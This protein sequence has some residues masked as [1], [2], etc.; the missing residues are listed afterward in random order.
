MSKDEKP[1]TE[2]L[3]DAQDT[4]Y[5]LEESARGLRTQ[6]RSNGWS[7][8]SSEAVAAQ[9]FSRALAMSLA[10]ADAMTHDE[11]HKAK[12]SGWDLLGNVLAVTAGLLA[13]PVVIF[14]SIA[15]GRWAL[16]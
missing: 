13:L 9:W 2:N 14:V 15:L 11:L 1:I 8:E 16:G 3:A 12:A 4:L 7:D 10:H 6:M 5:L